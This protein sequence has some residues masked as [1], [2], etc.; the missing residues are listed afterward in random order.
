MFLHP[1]KL[2]DSFLPRASPGLLRDRGGGGNEPVAACI[3][4]LPQR[5]LRDGATLK[6]GKDL[7]N[8]RM[9]YRFLV[10][11]PLCQLPDR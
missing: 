2:G 1:A 5:R 9:L 7:R 6:V 4:S 10:P 11:A 3:E 8:V